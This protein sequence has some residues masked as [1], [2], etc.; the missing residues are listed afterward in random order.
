M[1]VRIKAAMFAQTSLN[2]N[3]QSIIQQ[4]DLGI[5]SSEQAHFLPHSLCF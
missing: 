4:T 3:E 5:S 2:T 1:M